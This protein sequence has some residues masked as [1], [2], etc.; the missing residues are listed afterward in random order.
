MTNLPVPDDFSQERNFR[1]LLNTR[2]DLQVNTFVPKQDNLDLLALDKL[3]A[4]AEVTPNKTFDIKESKS[5]SMTEVYS[6]VVNTLTNDRLEH[7][8]LVEW[9]NQAWMETDISRKEKIATIEAENDSRFFPDLSFEQIMDVGYLSL[10]TISS[11]GETRR[12]LLD[13]EPL[14]DNTTI[15]DRVFVNINVSDANMKDIRQIIVEEFSPNFAASRVDS[16]MLR[17]FSPGGTTTAI[18][19]DK[20]DRHLVHDTQISR[21]DITYT[22]E[23]TDVQ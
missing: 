22:C 6:A 15:E 23:I 9:L 13:I 10:T 21:A 12:A 1:P 5:D 7:R 3:S 20:I 16:R 19:P 11:A 4:A 8:N 14:F 17:M 18:S 2:C